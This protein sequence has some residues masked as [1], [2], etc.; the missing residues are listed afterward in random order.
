MS[1]IFVDQVD[2]KTGTSLTLGTSG[3]TV[4]IPS[5]VTIANAGTATGFGVSLANGVDNRVIT[6]SS[7]TALNGEANLTF[8]GTDLTLGTGNIV[9]GTAS[10]GVYL[11]V[12]AATASNLLD[13]YEEGTFT[14]TWITSGGNLS[15]SGSVTPAS[16]SGKYTKI[17]DLVTV[18][19]ITGLFSVTGTSGSYQI[20]NLPFATNS[21]QPAVG[22]VREYGQTGHLGYCY[23]NGNSST[24]VVYGTTTAGQVNNPYFYGCITYKV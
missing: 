7:A 17:G 19:F 16:T 1:K 13:D 14:P 23:I 12:T 11:G 15:P 10:K 22:A 9:F 6:S 3:D 4:N 18:Q 24:A 21:A 5:G 20:T 2:P 8:D